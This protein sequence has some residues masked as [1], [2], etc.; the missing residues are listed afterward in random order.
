VLRASAGANA[1]LAVLRSRLV[2][3]RDGIPGA[4]VGR[5]LT[6]GVRGWVVG[7]VVCLA[8]APPGC[9]LWSNRSSPVWLGRVEQR[10]DGG[11]DLRFAA[12]GKGFPYD[13]DDDP[14]ALAFFDEWLRELGAE[15]GA[16]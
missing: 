10:A 14:S 3:V 16:R 6:P 11:S 5:E 12:Y 8:V 7:G 2:P 4:Y 13:A 15:V 1:S 9:N